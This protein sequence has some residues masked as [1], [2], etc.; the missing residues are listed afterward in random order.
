MQGEG[1]KYW[2]L[3][4]VQKQVWNTTRGIDPRE[5]VEGTW[6][7]QLQSAVEMGLIT[8]DEH[9]RAL[10]QWTRMKNSS[11]GMKPEKGKN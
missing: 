4:P 2:E 7:L 6:E 8:P 5:D 10:M 9:V 1:P 11:S 3:S